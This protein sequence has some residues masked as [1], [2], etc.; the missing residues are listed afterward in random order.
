M[1]RYPVVRFP[2]PM[3]FPAS[4]PSPVPF[5]QAKIFAV[6]LATLLALRD[7]D[8]LSPCPLGRSTSSRPAFSCWPLAWTAAVTLR[9][10]TVRSGIGGRLELGAGNAVS[11]GRGRGL[12]LL[13]QSR[14]SKRTVAESAA[15][16]V[17]RAGGS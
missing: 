17:S 8:V 5:L 15:E 7:P 3:Q 2:F 11:V 16:R 9:P 14:S 6:P 10:R 12:G 1:T 13:P 4:Q